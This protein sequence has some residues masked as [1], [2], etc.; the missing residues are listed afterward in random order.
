MTAG[1]DTALHHELVRR[2]QALHALKAGALAMFDPMLAAVAS[3]RDDE[4]F[5][6]VSDLLGRMHGV[7]GRH[8]EAT[9]NHAGRLAARLDALGSGPS[10]PRTAAVGAGAAVRARAGT[11]GGMNF[12]AGARDAFVFE[13]LEIAEA[14]L[15]EQ[16]AERLG[17]TE[18]ATV[19]REVRASDEEQAAT[20]GRN[21][22][23][24]LSL[25]LA[26]RGLPVRRPAEAAA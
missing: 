2:L 18:T 7:F 1:T 25:A 3:A 12:G 26:S 17:D 10:R 6:E 13:H 22:T 14:H 5:A 9:A 15:L 11:I 21:W 19:A 24:V 8:R 16:L 20:I 4:G 23:N